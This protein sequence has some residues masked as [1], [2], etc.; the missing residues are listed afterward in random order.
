MHGTYIKT[1]VWA[2]NI[3]I[4]STGICVTV[5]TMNVGLPSTQQKRL[6]FSTHNRARF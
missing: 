2:L 4:W 6:R 1:I 5:V 3:R